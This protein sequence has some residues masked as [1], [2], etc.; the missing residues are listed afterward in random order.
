M[1][2]VV[3]CSVVNAHLLPAYTEPTVPEELGKNDAGGGQS[4]V[5]HVT[6]S[7]HVNHLT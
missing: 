5:T 6:S 4:R 1:P 2:T 3:G 7:T